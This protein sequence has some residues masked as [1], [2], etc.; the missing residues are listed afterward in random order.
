MLPFLG[1]HMGDYFNQW[2]QI[3]RTLPNPPQIFGVNWFRKDAQGNFIWPGFGD[4]MRILKWIIDR[5]NGTGAAVESPIG[6]MPR[7]RHLDWAGMEQFTRDEYHA[8]MSIDR[9]EWKKELLGHHE[10]FEQLYDR[11]PKEFLF[12]REL[13]LSQLWRSPE[14]WKNEYNLV[15]RN[16]K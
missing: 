6:W 10:L 8:I 14:H 3:G 12:M 9:E 2:L 1:Y 16:D 15:R 11:L 13:L 5:S 4:N 7:F